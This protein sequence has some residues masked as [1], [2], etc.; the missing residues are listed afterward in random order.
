[1]A[2]FKKYNYKQDTMLVINFEEQLQPGTFEYAVHHLIDNKLDLS[3]FYP[4]SRPEIS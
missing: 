4:M 2:R 1:M 3:I